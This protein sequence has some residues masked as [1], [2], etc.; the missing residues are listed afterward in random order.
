MEKRILMS[1]LVIALAA[2]MVGGATVAIFTAN[3]STEQTTYSAGK[4]AI[5]AGE[6]EII[7]GNDIFNN[8]VSGDIVEGQFTIT[9]SGTLEM[10]YKMEAITEGD[11]FT[12]DTPA[13]VE[14]RNGT[15]SL[16]P[17]D[18]IRFDNVEITDSERFVKKQD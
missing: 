1:M 10:W 3:A 11:L 18:E 14:I 5:D 4:I 2:A 16:L 7:E 17:Q 12:G 6:I 9:N 15:G 13:Y 8:M